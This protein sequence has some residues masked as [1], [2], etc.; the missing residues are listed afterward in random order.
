VREREKS[1]EAKSS[2]NTTN[3]KEKKGENS[4]CDFWCESVF[5]HFNKAEKRV[6]F[7]RRHRNTTKQEQI[8]IKPR[9]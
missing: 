1:S 7:S 2:Q 5:L 4:V 3:Q 6:N 9:I 8:I